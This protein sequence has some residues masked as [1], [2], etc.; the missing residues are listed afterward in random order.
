MKYFISLFLLITNLSW[1]SEKYCETIN[2]KI[3][4]L[5]DSYIFYDEGVTRIW[6]E[7]YDYM[8][9]NGCDLSCKASNTNL[10]KKLLSTDFMVANK[11]EFNTYLREWDDVI[12]DLKDNYTL[13]KYCN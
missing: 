1:G 10:A 3:S 4:D 12:A 9:E 8:L 11:K 7:G 2:D 5:Q 6:K 13:W